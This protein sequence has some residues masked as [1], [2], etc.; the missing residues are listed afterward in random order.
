MAEQSDLRLTVL[1]DRAQAGTVEGGIFNFVINRKVAGQEGTNVRTVHKVIPEFKYFDDSTTARELLLRQEIGLHQFF[2]TE[3]PRLA[4]AKG[5][6]GDIEDLITTTTKISYIP[7]KFNFIFFRIANLDDL[8]LNVDAEPLEDFDAAQLADDF[9]TLI[10][11]RPAATYAGLIIPTE[12]A[13]GDNQEYDEMRENKIQWKSEEDGSEVNGDPEELL[14]EP[15]RV[16]HVD[17]KSVV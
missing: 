6:L 14:I 5:S 4:K 10:N 2:S 12:M 7:E 8:T 1:N 3:K 16:K 13:A 11:G 17:R 15:Q 9:F